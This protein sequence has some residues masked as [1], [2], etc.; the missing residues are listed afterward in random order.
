M[1]IR[2]VIGGFSKNVSHMDKL[3]EFKLREFVYILV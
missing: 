1:F 3:Q 2:A